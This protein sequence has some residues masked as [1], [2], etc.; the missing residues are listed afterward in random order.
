MPCSL[1]AAPM[2]ITSALAT[3]S[4]QWF[5][6]LR[7]NRR[8][9]WGFLSLLGESVV[10]EAVRMHG[11]VLRIDKCC[12]WAQVTTPQSLKTHLHPHLHFPLH[13]ATGADD[14]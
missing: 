12:P 5:R 9:K 7:R 14:S 13:F 11:R 6:S 1:S 8:A 4:L 10:C 2:T 3:A